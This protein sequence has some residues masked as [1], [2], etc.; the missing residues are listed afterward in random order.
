M[1][2]HLGDGP[3][4]PQK[5]PDARPFPCV[6][7]C[8]STLVPFCTGIFPNVTRVVKVGIEQLCLAQQLMK[9]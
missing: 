7:D 3:K 4:T 2:T 5:T 6:T 9:D 8:K 1:P